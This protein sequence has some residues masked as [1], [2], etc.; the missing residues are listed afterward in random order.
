[1]KVHGLSGERVKLKIKGRKFTGHVAEVRAEQ[2][3]TG[4]QSPVQVTL[5]IVLDQA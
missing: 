5:T 2:D 4:I 3:Y 1:M